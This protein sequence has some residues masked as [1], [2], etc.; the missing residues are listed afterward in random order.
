MNIYEKLS[1]ILE[2]PVM[3]ATM[4]LIVCGAIFTTLQSIFPH[5][6]QQPR[7]RKD[8]INDVI[9]WIS[10]PIVY[11]GI[12]T[13][14]LTG[15]LW[16]IFRG[17]MNA[18]QEYATKGGQWIQNI[19]L[20]GQMILVLLFTD[21]SLYWT[22]RLFHA[23]NSL[24]KYHAIHH[25]AQDMDWM[26]SVRFHPINVIFHSVWANAL[27]IWVG[28]P[29]VAIVA[30][31][32]FNILYSAMVHSN[33]NWTFGPLKYVFAS[34]VFHRWHHTSPQEGGN[35]NFAATFT[36]LDLAFGTYYMPEGKLPGKTGV[37]EDYVPKSIIGQLIFPFFGKTPEEEQAQDLQHKIAAE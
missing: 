5:D 3:Q 8:A 13:A 17:D 37:Y 25:G 20:W 33:L 10:S 15:G 7:F 28:F 23:Y 34:P 21:L 9:Y 16:L 12:S 31:T 27:A 22:H 14:M 4:W 18:A 30:L 35:M 32:P 6:K 24:W 1:P 2:Q 26:H 19:P 36:F 29:P 11:S